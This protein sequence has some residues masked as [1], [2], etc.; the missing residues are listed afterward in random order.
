MSLSSAI[1]TTNRSLMGREIGD[2]VPG[3]PGGEYDALT[4][5]VD[6]FPEEVAPLLGDLDELL[7]IDELSDAATDVVEQ[8]N[9][10]FARGSGI[11]KGAVFR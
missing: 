4:E 3:I 6:V 10:C 9:G 2:G 5:E 11:S 1:R 8:K 7:N